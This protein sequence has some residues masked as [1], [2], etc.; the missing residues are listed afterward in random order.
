TTVRTAVVGSN[1]G[2]SGSR[3]CSTPGT[4][5]TPTSTTT[6]TATPSMTPSGSRARFAIGVG[7]RKPSGNTHQKDSGWAEEAH[8]GR[9]A[10]R[11]TAHVSRGIA[12]VRLRRGLGEQLCIVPA[13][14]SV[15]AGAGDQPVVVV[16][17]PTS[18]WLQER[19][20]YLID[21]WLP[22]SV[23]SAVPHS[24]CSL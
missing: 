11:R 5:R 1:G 12:I 22:V 15:K 23:G 8:H 3:V 24:Q 19:F 6:T 2:P 18:A 4:T 13:L 7:G 9:A 16:G 14:R 20:P 10:M 21:E 17:G